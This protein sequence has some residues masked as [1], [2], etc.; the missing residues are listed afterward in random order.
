MADKTPKPRRSYVKPLSMFP[1]TPEEALAALL[2]VPK[3]DAA[4]IRDES[5][6]KM[7][8]WRKLKK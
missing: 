6:A 2:A 7:R 8:T 5:A 1:L 3:E 4:K